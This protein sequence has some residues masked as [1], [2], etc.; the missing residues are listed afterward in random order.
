[1]LASVVVVVLYPVFDYDMYWHLANGRE[2]LSTGHLV[3][4]ERFSYTAFGTPFS[5]HE[6]LSQILF[7]LIYDLWGG[8]GLLALKVLVTLAIAVL[9][10][11]TCRV[12]G[13]TS[14]L[15]AMLV[16][17]AVT[18]GFY[19]YIERPELFSLLGIAALS[20]LLY[21][22]RAQRCDIKFLFLIPGILVLWDS[23]HGAIFGLI[24]LLA[25]VA[26]ENIK[27]WFGA[28]FA[29]WSG[30]VPMSREQLRVLNIVCGLTLLALLADPYGLRSYDIFLQF[31]NG[32]ALVAGVMEFQPANWREHKLFWILLAITLAALIGARRTLDL[33]QLLVVAPFA[34]LAV[35]YSRVIGV[36]ALLDAALLATLATQIISALAV[37]RR[38][39]LLPTLALSAFALALAAYIVAIKFAGPH[40]P[41]SFGYRI[42]DEFLPAGSVRFIQDVNLP[43][44]LYNSGHFGGYLA[45]FITPQRR[46]FQYN[47]HTVFGDT[48]RYLDHP[49]ELARWNIN[50]AV[51]GSPAELERLFPITEW[52]RIYREP[53]A[54]VVLRRTAEN[55]ALIER[56]EI[57]SFHPMLPAAVLRT[58]AQRPQSYARLMYEMATYLTYREDTPMTDLFAELLFL[59]S[60]MTNAERLELLQHVA[61][62]NGGSRQLTIA[63]I[64]AGDVR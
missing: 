37:K 25:F 58:M 56:Y 34:I 35:R 2:M 14:A 47:H 36:F 55:S 31:I 20:Y 23:L 5:N 6:W 28:R 30:M 11:R 38:Y 44:N 13:A 42:S 12:H 32:N 40:T 26:G 48:N 52:A 10:Y 8:S 4:E 18:A 21:C 3:N 15:S 63:L 17:A 29:H 33:T 51:V 7:F 62:L 45:F 43:G 50:Y 16:V 27:H 60:A 22:C 41:Q 57:F 64:K 46:I 54:V 53:S 19:R 59:N 49:E 61:R 24:V 9:V 1:M 39:P